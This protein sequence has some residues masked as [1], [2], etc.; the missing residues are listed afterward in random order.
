MVTPPPL[1]FIERLATPKCKIVKQR[2][3]EIVI[4]PEVKKLMSGQHKKSKF[5]TINE[6]NEAI[7][8]LTMET[9][10]FSAFC[11]LMSNLL[12]ETL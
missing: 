4:D 5:R 11:T 2:K 3:H 6:M 1:S 12:V 9:L 10:S 8:Q 7:K